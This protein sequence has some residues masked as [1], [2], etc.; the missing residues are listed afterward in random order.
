MKVVRILL[1]LG[2][3]AFLIA[4]ATATATNTPRQAN[5]AARKAAIHLTHRFHDPDVTAGCGHR[6]SGWRCFV[7]MNGHQC[8]GTLR[9]T[10]SL[11][12]YRS[13]IRCSG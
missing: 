5:A 1:V 13:R 2:A 8:H 9:L 4:A 12:A 7:R 10:G 6:G 11:H 3:V